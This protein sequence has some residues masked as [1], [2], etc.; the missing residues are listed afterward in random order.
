MTHLHRQ[1]VI[2]RCISKNHRITDQDVV[3]SNTLREVALDFVRSYRGTNSFVQSIAVQLAD[4]GSLSPAQMRGALNVMVAEARNSHS[5]D[6]HSAEASKPV[7]LSDGPHYERKPLTL[8]FTS[9]LRAIPQET[10]PSDLKP[11]DDVTPTVVTNQVPNGTYTVVLNDQGDYRTICLIDCPEHFNKPAGT[12]IAQYLSGS[13][14]ERNYTGFAFVSPHYF[15]I[16]SKF[17]KLNNGAAQLNAALVKLLQSEN[18]FEYGQAYAMR[19]GKCFVCRR[20][21]TTP[22]SIASGIG[23][24]CAA[25]LGIYQQSLA[26][27]V[28]KA[29]TPTVDYDQ[30]IKDIMELFPE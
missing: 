3:S 9:K 7:D 19:S 23:P 1:T 15:T 17:R 26:M 16:W 22:D 6:Q 8:D 10:L 20:K 29:K 28:N 18:P 21:L 5:I 12:Q 24:I 30:A 27:A 11:V 14:N 2:D 25:N 13:D 4:R